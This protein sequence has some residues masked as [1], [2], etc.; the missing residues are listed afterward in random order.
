MAAADIVLG[1]LE[2]C[3]AKLLDGTREKAPDMVFAS[4][5]GACFDFGLPTWWWKGTVGCRIWTE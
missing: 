3:V 5:L 1:S 4:L 2:C